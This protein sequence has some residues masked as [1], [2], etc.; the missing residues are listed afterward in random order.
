MGEIREVFADRFNPVAIPEPGTVVIAGE[1]PVVR[2]LIPRVPARLV[3]H[4]APGILRLEI[5]R[6]AIEESVPV[7]FNPGDERG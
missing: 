5:S 1:D 4:P 7:G 3:A 6:Q 2:Q